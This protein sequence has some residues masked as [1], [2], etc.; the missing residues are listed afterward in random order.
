MKS[1]F[2]AHALNVL[3]LSGFCY[4][5]T[6][7]IRTTVADSSRV[8]FIAGIHLSID[9]VSHGGL[10]FIRFSDAPVTDSTGFPEL[11]V[12][13]VLVAVPDSVTPSV[14]F[15][16]SDM[17]YRKTVPVYPSPAWYVSYTR[18]AAEV[19][20]FTMDSTAYASDAFWPENRIDVLGKPGSA[21][22]A[23]SSCSCIRRSTGLPTA[24]SARSHHS[25][26]PSRSTAQRLSGAVLVWT[27]SK[28]GSRQSN[29]GLSA[30]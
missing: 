16:V 22:S 30:N 1:S 10:D 29:G 4:A 23:S 11:P 6:P 18:T 17:D 25:A 28:H 21:I 26:C 15:T 12:V 13:T 8:A 24:S 14:D 19:D 9:S 3:L 2:Y 20:S 7:L 5:D 27:V